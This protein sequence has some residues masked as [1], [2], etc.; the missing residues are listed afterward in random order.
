MFNI[1]T[2]KNI[3]V[4]LV[5]I[6]FFFFLFSQ[7]HIYQKE[8]LEYGITFSQKQA[9]DLGFAWQAVYLAILN[10]LGVK[11]IRLPAYWNEIE[12]ASGQYYWDDLDWQLEQASKVQAEIVLAVGGRLPRWPECYFPDWTNGLTKVQREEAILEYIKKVVERYKSQEEITAWQ[13]EN[14]PFLAH[15]GDCPTLDSKFLDKEIALVRSLDSRPIII[16]DSGELSV[17]IPAARRADIFGTTM[18]SDTYS[19]IF[20]SYIHYPITPG[21]FRLKKNLAKIFAHPKEWLVIELQ[22]EPWGPQPYQDLSQA[23]R[24]RTMN[25]EKFREII[26][27]ARQAGFR[28]FYLWGAEW[29]YWEKEKNNN[30]AIWEEARMLFNKSY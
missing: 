12:S 24:D 17:W 28:Q 16:T 11:K 1:R 14:E 19:K 3:F 29:W 7:G 6:I 25:L 2:L 26:E 4:V 8:E 5:I 23:E 15:F 18:Y 10:D 9:Q 21:F 22:A 20:K 13:V 27:F 30:P